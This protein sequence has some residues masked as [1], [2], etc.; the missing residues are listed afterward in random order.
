[1]STRL[2]RSGHFEARFTYG[3]KPYSRTFPTARQ[4]EAWEKRTRRALAEGLHP[5][6]L[7]EDEAEPQVLAPLFGDYARSWLRDRPLKPSTKHLYA[8]IIEGHL[9]PKWEA[10]RLDRITVQAVQAWHRSLLPGS[11]TRRA[12]VYALLRTILGTAVA[13][14]VISAN[15]CRVRGGGNTK[16]ESTTEIPS[17]AAIG[18]LI[19]AMPEGKYRTLVL[20]AVWCGLRQG[21]ILELRRRDLHLDSDGSVTAVHVS[22]AVYRGHVDTPKT[23]AGKRV[24]SV[25]PH[26]RADLTDWLEE[27]PAARSALLFPGSQPGKPIAPDTLRDVFHRACA[28]AGVSMRFHDLRHVSATLAA[29]SGATVGEL[30]ARI[31][32]STPHMALRYQGATQERDA[33]IAA[34][35]SA[36]A[37]PDGVV[38]RLARPA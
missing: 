24:V 5:D 29:R 31:G 26:M 19:E 14:D 35:M 2:I 17:T 28:A 11:P 16:R 3:G 10:I 38:V 21:E 22:R 8:G 9:V 4:G 23:R 32:H 1:M 15:P 12:H 13:D 20:V 37:E 33:A 30:Q 34:A 18:R 7:V 36:H 6:A 25:P 27:R